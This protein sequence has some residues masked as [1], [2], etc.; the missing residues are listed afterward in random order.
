MG[1]KLVLTF[2]T[3]MLAALHAQSP[4][5]VGSA[6]CKTCHAE[7]YARW[8]KT[9]MANVVRDP[10]AH[11]DAILPDLSTNNIARFTVDQVAFVR[12]M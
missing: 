11:P 3:A 7:T 6:A 2:S 9:R 12:A 5:Y 4:Q 1:G 10:K 8:S